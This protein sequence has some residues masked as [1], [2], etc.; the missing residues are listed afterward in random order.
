MASRDTLS[1]NP[2]CFSRGISQR[3]LSPFYL[4]SL[5]Y[6]FYLGNLNIGMTIFHEIEKLALN[7]VLDVTLVRMPHATWAIYSIAAY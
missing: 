4:T 7:C 5:S 2:D 6:Y 1:F 3:G